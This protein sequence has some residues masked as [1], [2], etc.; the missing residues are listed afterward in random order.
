MNLSRKIGLISA[1]L[2]IVADVIGTGIFMT[3]GSILNM[4]Q[5]APVVLALW[6][7]GGLVALTGSLSYAELASIWPEDGGEYI[8]LRNIFGPLPSF[9]TGWISLI[10][11]F[12]TAV[13]ISS[14]TCV[15][16]FN[17]FFQVPFLSTI[18]G[19]KLAAALLI[20]LFG[21]IH[22]LG[23]RRGT[24]VQNGLTVLKITL[25][26][27]LII[28]GFVI[29][30]P[31]QWERVTTVYGE[32]PGGMIHYGFVLLIVMFAYSGWNGATYIAGEIRDPERNLPRALFFGTLIVTVLYL[33]LN[34]VYL[35]AVPG[36]ELMETKTVGTAAAR[37]LM[38]EGL[39]PFFTLA[40]ALILLSSVSVQMQVGPR[41]YYAMARDGMIFRWFSGISERFNTP[42]RSILIQTVIAVIYVFL[43]RESIESLLGYMGFALGIFPLL[44]I[45]GLVM[46]RYRRPDIQGGYR[47]PL[48]PVIPLI[49]IILTLVMMIASLVTWTKTS[50]TA[51]GVVCL[52]IL[53][54]LVWKRVEKLD[55]SS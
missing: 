44:A 32:T 24:W 40:I 26:V 23:V 49:H 10:V 16:Y 51:I 4:T 8:Y 36:A 55:E 6:G 43:G 45:I 27:A 42:H 12:S 14:I 18:F 31:P 5:S 50:M 19:Q 17:E 9:L 35:G 34:L 15:L 22:T 53:V 54:Y 28:T 7:I 33:L 13:A 41:V 48:F 21:V 39:S 25:V 38:G 2:I 11:G 3:T 46:I 1:I 47:T 30:E 20:V 29:L 52:G 37:H